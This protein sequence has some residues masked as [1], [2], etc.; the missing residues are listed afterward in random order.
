M[1]AQPLRTE[2]V[3]RQ[4]IEARSELAALSAKVAR[5]DELE[6]ALKNRTAVCRGLEQLL[7]D[8]GHELFG[9][10]ER[11]NRQARLVGQQTALNLVVE[12]A[13]LHEVAPR[14]LS[15]VAQ[16]MEWD[17]AI[18]WMEDVGSGELRC[19]EAWSNDAF[20]RLREFV[21]A[22][23][24]LAFA[25]H[26][27]LPGTVWAS[28]EPHALLDISAAG[29][30]PRS[31][32]AAEVGLHSSCAFPIIESKKVR[33]VM[34]FVSR[35]WRE[36]DAD[37]LSA[38]AAFGAQLGQFL[39]LQRAKQALYQSELSIARQVQTSILPR[40]LKVEGLD[41]SARML[42]AEDVGGDYY[43]V[44]PTPG[45]CWIAVGDVSGHGLKAGLVTL[46]LQ[47]AMATLS[48]ARPNASP[49]EVLPFINEMLYE[50]IRERQSDDHHVTLSLLRYDAN[51]QFEIAGAHEDLIV[52]QAATRKCVVLPTSGTWLGAIPDT[53]A[54]PRR[55][56]AHEELSSAG[57]AWIQ[58]APSQRRL[59]IWGRAPR[60]GRERGIRRRRPSH[61]SCQR[62]PRSF[63]R[64]NV[65][66]ILAD[67]ADGHQD[68][69]HGDAS[70]GGTHGPHRPQRRA[71]AL[72]PSRRNHHWTQ[73]RLQSEAGRSGDKPAPLP[74]HSQQWWHVFDRG[75]GL[76]QR[77]VR[78]WQEDRADEARRRR[79]RADRP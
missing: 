75:L 3:E 16:N 13:S 14:L 36:V 18:L 9:T 54:S 71:G 46:M 68:P 73:P 50:N 59:F 58:G 8:K 19:L 15:L 33:G 25:E 28:K 63:R 51:G 39:E 62:D 20:P 64:G 57:I 37:L 42:P 40:N 79:A 72:P 23:R 41:V 70:A 53:G 17:V 48:R 32:I 44:L 27:D 24:A 7:E 55:V 65:G 4:L 1:S 21:D 77:H 29:T 38:L 49:S 76:H 78:Q 47:S 2:D 45:G 10:L 67:L 74:N 11:F 56:T 31:A 22:S 66:G 60:A 5:V 69:G 34:E 26:I 52:F 43:D 61:A 6:Q 35:E 12:G 30:G